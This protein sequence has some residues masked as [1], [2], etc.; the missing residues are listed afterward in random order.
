MYA[1]LLQCTAT[2]RRNYVLTVLG[3]K[4]VTSN[5]KF[6][7]LFFKMYF[8]V[9]LQARNQLWRNLKDY[10][11]CGSSVILPSFVQCLLTPAKA[12]N[13][14]PA[15]SSVTFPCGLPHCMDSSSWLPFSS[16]LG[17]IFFPWQLGV[18]LEMLSCILVYSGMRKCAWIL[19]LR[20]VHPVYFYWI[21]LTWCVYLHVI[22]MYVCR[23]ERRAC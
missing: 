10:C 18:H 13:W 6:I 14:V 20:C 19:V 7:D 2:M 12:D 3:R 8:L 11:A 5:N 23:R 9:V 1:D 15:A 17:S 22:S 16:M 21:M 4:T